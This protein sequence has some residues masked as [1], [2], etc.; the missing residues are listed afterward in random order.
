MRFSRFMLILSALFLG[1]CPVSPASGQYV[2]LV[3]K[4]FDPLY[5]GQQGAMSSSSCDLSGAGRYLVFSSNS[6]NLVA[7][8]TNGEQDIFVLDRDMGEVTRVNVD[9]SGNQ[10]NDFS[11][12][13]RIST[14]GRYVVFESDADNLVAGD[15]NE[16]DDI[17]RHDLLTGETIRVSLVDN[18]VAESP[19]G[20]RSPSISSDG[21]RVAFTS[22]SNLV[23]DDF[24]GLT[25]AYVR[26]ISSSDTTRVSTDPAFADPDGNTHKVEISGDGEWV[27]M[28][29]QA[30][31]L[32]SGDGNGL[33]DVFLRNIFSGVTIR[34]PALGGADPDAPAGISDINSDG[35]VVVFISAATNYV[36]GVTNGQADVFVYDAVSGQVELISA[37]VMGNGGN[38]YSQ[39][40][41]VSGAGRYVAFESRADDLVPVDINPEADAFVY[42]RQ[43]GSMS[44]VSVASGGLQATAGSAFN[45]CL[46]ASSAILA[47]ATT[48]DEL[49][50]GDINV[51]TDIVTHARNAGTTELGSLSGSGGPYPL[52]PG[53]SASRVSSLSDD[54]RFALFSSRAVNLLGIESRLIDL[55]YRADLDTGT[56]TH[57]TEAIAGG[58]G[59]GFNS[60]GHSLDATGTRVAFSSRS[61]NLVAADGNGFDDVFVRD[62]ALG[63]TRRISL[64]SAGGEVGGASL[65]PEISG[66]GTTV[67]FESDAPDL[68]GGD[69]NGVMDIFT[70]E[71]AGGT[72]ERV[73]VSGLGDEANAAGFAPDISHDG[74]YV[75]FHSSASNL[76]VPDVNGTDIFRHDR[77]SGDTVLVS[78]DT[79]GQQA[80]GSHLFASLSADGQRV[81]FESSGDTL[82]PGDGNGEKDIFL[83]DLVAGTT[84]LVSLD[85][86]NLQFAGTSDTARLSADGNY[87]VFRVLPENGDP[88]Q[89]YMRDIA[90]GRTQLISRARSGAPGGMSSLA[91]GVSEGGTR[92]LFGSDG[93][94]LAAGDINGLEDVFVAE[95][96]TV[97]VDSFEG[98]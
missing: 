27:A 38:D 92:V 44:L 87:V 55:I 45:M 29:S 33:V 62:M 54:G 77:L 8:D 56:V 14:N 75:V 73:N 46:S 51:A 74:R 79:A 49:F 9:S 18:G 97:F 67:A 2:K 61:T 84:I 41:V 50:P 37:N 58:P 66:D 85:P 52:I 22:A 15:T 59:D 6:P 80:G 12:F 86:D 16:S 3:S 40:G 69:I 24:N 88:R 19:A 76:V 60:A 20:G 57:V 31:N 68:V 82:V 34:L 63:M 1:A 10:A 64:D 43:T 26:I 53:S 48:S 42:D 39:S 72:T 25:D 17:F 83:R 7:G 30:G 91:A 70:H 23:G 11:R 96:G 4:A 89:I 28:E 35:Q 98:G 36:T 94:D 21:D 78:L 81:A 65:N 5:F 71:I 47:F 95:I 93:D 32:V 13:P 90:A